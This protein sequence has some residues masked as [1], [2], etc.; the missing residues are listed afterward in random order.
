MLKSRFPTGECV[1]GCRLADISF[2]PEPMGVTFIFERGNSTL[3]VFVANPRKSVFKDQLAKEVLRVTLFLESIFFTYLTPQDVLD[4]KSGLDGTPAERFEQYINN[5][6]SA[7]QSVGAF[8]EPICLKVLNYK[9]NPSLPKYVSYGGKYLPFIKKESDI[10]R[11][12][13]YTTYENQNYLC[14]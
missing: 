4:A 14:H 6:K 8:E 5:I 12:L 7:L 1:C 3:R 13:R 9:G 11:D 2:T 10:T